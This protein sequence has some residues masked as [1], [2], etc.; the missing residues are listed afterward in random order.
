MKNHNGEI[1]IFGAHI[2]SQNLIFNGLDTSSI[3]YILDNDPDKHD[4]ILYGT[5]L[6]VKS[7]NIIKK[8]NNPLIILRAAAYN[9]EIKEGIMSINQNSKFL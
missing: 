2:F 5:N 4:Q 1:Y 7:P 9:N 3:N 8:N 6:E